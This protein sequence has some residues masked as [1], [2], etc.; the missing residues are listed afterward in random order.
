MGEDDLERVMVEFVAHKFDVL[1]ATTIVEN[2]LDIPNANTIIINRADRYGLAQ[3]YQLRGRVGRS[4]RRAYAYLLIPAEQTLSPVARKRLAAIREFSDLGSGFRIA[5]LDLE[6]RGAG[7][8]LGGEQ[9][10]HIE[11]VGFDMYMKLL[12]E[13][14]RE[15]KGED[16]EDDRR[17]AVNLRLDLRIDQSYIPDMNQRLS[18]YRRLASARTLDEVT[19]FVAELRDRYGAAPPSVEHLAQ[20]SRI[21]VMADR[22][23]LESLDR[24]STTVVLKFRQDAK[25]DPT[26]L[27]RLIQSRRDLTLLPPAVIRMDM[28]RTSEASSSTAEV[29][30]RRPGSPSAVVHPPKPGPGGTR[31]REIGP[32]RR[33]GA[34]VLV[35]GPGHL[36]NRARLHPARDSGRNGAGSGRSGRVVRAAGPGAR[37]VESIAGSKLKY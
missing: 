23:G 19:R 14:I 29:L 1:L 8:L 20:Y 37:P 3:L 15:L 21:R 36:G 33:P 24:E 22:I 28:T 4:D 11:A 25:I 10:G 26:M 17:A 18:A 16:L 32:G 30:V 31:L 27:L 9:S 12:E 13:T 6:I 7:N 34:V 5:A 35:D 2:G